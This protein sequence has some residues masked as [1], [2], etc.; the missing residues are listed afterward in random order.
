LAGAVNFE[1]IA[2]PMSEMVG[3]TREVFEGVKVSDVAAMVIILLEITVGIFLMDSLRITRLLPIIGALDDKVRLRLVWFTFGI[4]FFLAA[5]ESGLAYMRDLLAAQ[6]EALNQLLAAGSAEE[7]AAPAFRW[8]PSVAQMV[9]GFILPFALTLVAIPLESFIHSSRSVF[10]RLTGVVLRLVGF[11][12]RLL[13]NL[14][15]GLA[16]TLVRLY[17]LL[18]FLP[19]SIDRAMRA[20]APQPALEPAPEA[21]LAPPVSTLMPEARAER[22]AKK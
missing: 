5:I 6:D 11:V 14:F 2:R 20:R 4:L 22:G 9:L 18:V 19:L 10:G 1:L 13:G 21:V 12:L 3:G 8:I 16:R 17:D 15:A 7:V